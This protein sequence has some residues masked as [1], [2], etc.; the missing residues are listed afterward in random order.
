[1]EARVAIRWGTA[2]CHSDT[3]TMGALLEKPVTEKET[4]IGEAN[5]LKYGVSGMQ[6][7]RTEM[8]DGHALYAAMPG[9]ANVCFFGVFDG[10]GGN[11]TADYVSRNLL[12]VVG[13]REEYQFFA[14]LPAQSLRD[15]PI[16]V[17]LLKAAL[18]G[19]YIDIDNEMLNCPERYEVDKEGSP[20]QDQSGCTAVVVLVTPTYILCANAGDSRAIYRTGGKTKRLSFDHKPNLDPEQDRIEAAGGYVSMKRVDGDLAV[21]RGLGDFRYKDNNELPPDRQKVSC[22]P[23]F[24]CVDRSPEKDEF[25]LLACDGIWDVVS[26]EECSDMVQ[27]ILDEGENDIG[28]ACEE[29]LDLCLEKNSKDNMTALM[30][31]FPG[32]LVGKGEGVAARRAKRQMKFDEEQRKKIEKEKAKEKLRAEADEVRKRLLARAR[33]EEEEPDS[34]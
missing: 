7:W 19:A 1:M 11:F 16:G 28:T 15:H 21:S 20:K 14:S 17:E 32:V 31:A 8:E 3:T 22:M 9:L 5:G 33:R 24:V 18:T 27:K 6:G 29:V 30:V 25:I 10:H 12:R 34:D 23:E 4:L 2:R 13:E 26:S